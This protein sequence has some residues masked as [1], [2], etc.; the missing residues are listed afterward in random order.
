MRI[1]G[2][3]QAAGPASIRATRVPPSS[4]SL[5]AMTQPAEPAPSTSTSVVWTA[6]TAWVAPSGIGA[7]S[8]IFPDHA[9]DGAA[10]LLRPDIGLADQLAP[11]R[12]LL[13]QRV[14][15]HAGVAGGDGNAVLG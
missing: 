10:P 4:E 1:Q 11:H 6:A 8:G 2:S 9:G 3:V 15:Q 13:R 14:A 5:V 12:R 7:S